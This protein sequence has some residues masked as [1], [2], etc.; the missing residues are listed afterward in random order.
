MSTKMSL[1]LNQIWINEEMLLT[2]THTH[3]HIYIYIYKVHN[4]PLFL[5]DSLH[6]CINHN[7]STFFDNDLPCSFKIIYS[8][9]IITI[10]MSCRRYGYPWP[11]HATSPYRSSPL[12]GFQ[13]HISYPHIAT[14]RM[15]ELVILLLLGHMWGSIGVHRS[16]DYTYSWKK[17]KYI[18]IYIYI[19]ITCIGSFLYLCL[20]P[21]QT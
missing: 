18:Y 8:L 4:F 10:I 9:T 11:S 2:H 6:P 19:Y 3:T 14:V 15:F 21:C 20:M 16:Y 12:A 13:V 17:K 7:L 1:M 5:P